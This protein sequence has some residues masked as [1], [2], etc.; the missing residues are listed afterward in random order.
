MKSKIKS[1]VEVFLTIR[2]AKIN[3]C[4]FLLATLALPVGDGLIGY[5]LSISIVN[6]FLT[7]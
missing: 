1:I 4:S 5:L 7:L 2:V 6:L 3:I